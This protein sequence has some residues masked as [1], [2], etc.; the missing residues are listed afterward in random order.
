MNIT[1]D[2]HDVPNCDGSP[3]NGISSS[4]ISLYLDGNNI[5]KAYIVADTTPFIKY[6]GMYEVQK[7]AATKGIVKQEIKDLWDSTK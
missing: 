5:T 7:R 6:P 4:F 1:R 3:T 2:G